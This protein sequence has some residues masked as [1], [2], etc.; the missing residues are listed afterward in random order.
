MILMGMAFL[1]LTLW[2]DFFA[3]SRGHPEEQ[4]SPIVWTSPLPWT[5]AIL[6]IAVHK[7]HLSE[8]LH[9]NAAVESVPKDDASCAQNKRYAQR[10]RG[11]ECTVHDASACP[12]DEPVCMCGYCEPSVALLRER[13]AHT[14]NVRTKSAAWR[15]NR[16]RENV[17]TFLAEDEYIERSDVYI[18]RCTEQKDVDRAQ[19]SVFSRMVA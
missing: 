6:N 14:I 10:K 4:R 11:E 3:L 9:K 13:A 2:L 7:E 18:E 15:V 16:G 5:A 19:Q 1:V 17:F 8:A 12:R